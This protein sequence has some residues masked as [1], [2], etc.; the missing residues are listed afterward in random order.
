MHWWGNNDNQSTTASRSLNHFSSHMDEL[1]QSSRV[2]FYGTDISSKFKQS[3]KNSINMRSTRRLSEEWNERLEITSDPI[4]KYYKLG[5]TIG[6]GNYAVVKQA[7]SIRTGSK[8]AVKIIKMR[9]IKSNFETVMQ[10]IKIL[11]EVSHPNIVKI[12]E[13]FKDKKKLYIVMEYVTGQELYDFIVSRNRLTEFES[14]VISEQ[15]LKIIKYLNS[16]NIVHRDLKPE[17]IMIDP[18]TCK[19]KLLDFGLSTHFSKHKSLMSPVGTP[20]YVSPEVL[21]GNYGKEWDMWS[22]GVITYILLTGSPPFEAESMTEI[23]KQITERNL[24]FDEDWENLSDNAKD[25]VT[26]LLEHDICLRMT[27][28]QALKHDWI[29]SNLPKYTNINLELLQHLI[30]S[31]K[32]SELRREIMMVLI[33]LSD[34]GKLNKWNEYF[35]S[36]DVNNSGVIEMKEIVAKLRERNIQGTQTEKLTKMIEIDPNWKIDYFDFLTRIIDINT[37]ISEQDIERAFKQFDVS[38]CG[39]ITDIGFKKFMNM[40][41]EKCTDLTASLILNQVDTDHVHNHSDYQCESGIDSSESCSR[42]EIGFNTFKNYILKSH[43]SKTL[44]CENS[45]KMMGNNQWNKLSKQKTLAKINFYKQSTR[46]WDEK[47][48][49]EAKA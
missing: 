12:F 29:T 1:R 21:S 20:Y 49:F 4:T 28:K 42:D 38:N 46:D 10:E 17:N 40:K 8:V 34:Q 44:V 48:E 37:D 22:I 32:P 11:K 33:Q 3:D 45:I 5:D 14:A 26:G 19:I 2:G 6:N 27:P 36:L 41:G 15:L 13:I 35:D 43:P 9:K 18:K 16:L 25:F 7:V 23:Y 31:H 47:F 24:T 30:H 39:K